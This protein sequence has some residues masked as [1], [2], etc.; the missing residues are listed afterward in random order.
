MESKAFILIRKD[1]VEVFEYVSNPVNMALW[2]EGVSEPRVTSNGTIGKGTTFVSKY[3]YGAGTYDIEYLVTDYDPPRCFGITSER[4][5]F[6]FKGMLVMEKDPDGTIVSNTI[7][8]GADGAFTKVM[9][10]LFSPLMKRSMRKQLRKELE[11]L[12]SRLEAS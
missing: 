5:P 7:D 9:F 12:K 2:V 6:P 3:T 8:A 1:P 4:G 10:T 11:V